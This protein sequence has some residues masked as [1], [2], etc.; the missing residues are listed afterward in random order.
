MS[1]E[2]LEAAYNQAQ[3]GGEHPDTI[4]FA[5]SG[6]KQFADD[7]LPE[8][9]RSKVLEFASNCPEGHCLMLTKTGLSYLKLDEAEDL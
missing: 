5:A 4:L 6:M 3:A 1:S 9:Q 2:E 7:S 8:P